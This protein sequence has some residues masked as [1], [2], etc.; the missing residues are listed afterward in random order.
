[1]GPI[2]GRALSPCF[3][4]L[5]MASLLHW[6]LFLPLQPEL[7]Q[8][9]SLCWD[10]HEKTFPFSSASL[11]VSCAFWLQ[12]CFTRTWLSSACQNPKVSGWEAVTTCC[13]GFRNKHEALK[14]PSLLDG[15]RELHTRREGN[16]AFVV[17]AL[18]VAHPG[19]LLS[20]RQIG[21]IGH[22]TPKSPGAMDCS[23]SSYPSAQIIVPVLSWRAGLYL[24]DMVD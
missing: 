18:K 15:G 4:R 1:M 19:K 16:Q 9:H 17:L 11:S 14:W 21:K 8:S 20:P 23:L 13:C 12:L 7:S 6:P 22:P 5:F 2:W 3:T 24:A 10:F